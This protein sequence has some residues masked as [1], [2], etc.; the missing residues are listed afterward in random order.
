MKSSQLKKK[1]REEFHQL[2]MEKRK[3]ELLED[4]RFIEQEE[5]IPKRNYRNFKSL[6]IVGLVCS[7]VLVFL[8]FKPI[9][10]DYFISFDVNPSIEIEVN[11]KRRVKDVICN[12][13]DAR[14]VME[15]MD[16]IDTD[17]DVAVNAIVGSMFRYGYISEV[18]NSILVT[19]LGENQ[20]V[21]EE[22]KK[23]VSKHVKEILSGYSVEASVV[24]QDLTFS[25]DT[26]E[27]A[28]KY[29]ISIGKVTL[30]QELM[31]QNPDYEFENLMHLTINDLNILVH[32]NNIQFQTITIDGVESHSGYKTSNEVKQSVLEHA[33]IDIKDI[34]EY[35]YYLDCKEGQL[36]YSVDFQDSY[37]K[38][39][40]DVNAVNGK[41]ISVN[42]DM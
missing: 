4:V 38:Y 7:M 26:K 19:I 2:Q 35:Q 34:I 5:I 28:Q 3:E 13:E 11:N 24:S 23:N 12:N 10:N 21:R 18:D 22:L 39:H 36:I 41:I 8:F 29:D 17:L 33:H 27:I 6:K 40:Y 14:I 1:L 9:E 31:Q 15:D 25:K 37:A 32:F 16:L 20:Q 42:L 30:I